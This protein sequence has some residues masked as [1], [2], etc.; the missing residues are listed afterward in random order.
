ME[1][2][3]E[4]IQVFPSI[5]IL[6]CHRGY[7]SSR[8]NVEDTC[9][10]VLSLHHVRESLSCCVNDE[11]GFLFFY[12][13]FHSLLVCQVTFDETRPWPVMRT[14]GQN[15]TPMKKEKEG[16]IER[17]GKNKKLRWKKKIKTMTK[18][19]KKFTTSLDYYCIGHPHLIMPCLPVFC[20]YNVSLLILY[21]S[22][23]ETTLES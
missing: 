10:L 5:S 11:V 21:I 16:M 3:E 18:R 7:V 1:H 15:R 23:G 20:T 9:L 4:V 2:N 12:Q 19:S 22:A 8:L 17:K 13:E 14:E 6:T